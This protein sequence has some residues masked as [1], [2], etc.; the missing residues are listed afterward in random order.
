MPLIGPPLVGLLAVA[1]QHLLARAVVLAGEGDLL[2][3]VAGDRH[4]ARHDVDAAVL[5]GRQA[6]GRG[7]HL[8]LD[9]VRVAED[10]LRDR[11]QHVDVEALDLPGDRVAGA[12]QQRVGRDARR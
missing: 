8:Q 7:D 10:R 3:A 9:L 6:L 5:E 11:V 2:P 12:E 4:V 1:H